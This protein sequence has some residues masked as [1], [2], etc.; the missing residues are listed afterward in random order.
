MTLK[1]IYIYLST[2]WRH[3]FISTPKNKQYKTP[4]KRP[5]GCNKYYYRSRHKT[6][7]RVKRNNR[8]LKNYGILI[9]RTTQ[10]VGCPV[11]ESRIK[12]GLNMDSDSY[13]ITIDSCCSY[14][15]AKS[16][17][18]FTGPLV[19]CNIKIQGLAQ[20]CNVKWK[21]T[22][23]FE[24]ED[25]DGITRTIKVP[26]TLYCKEAPYCLLSPQHWSQ[27]SKNPSGTYCK[28]GHQYIELIWQNS[29]L[30]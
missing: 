11:Q 27:Q 24:I 10:C 20:T 23:K 17:K 29:N 12:S 30:H 26:N 21:G 8:M 7:I 15:I 28:V 6:R 18:R 16:R 13:Q 25:D 14:S 9:S 4:K 5:K 3:E 22:W 2:M 1:F 19:P